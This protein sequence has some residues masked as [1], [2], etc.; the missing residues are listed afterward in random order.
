MLY[1]DLR[2]EF[3]LI[4]NSG[5]MFLTQSLLS[6]YLSLTEAFTQFLSKLDHL[7]SGLFCFDIESCDFLFLPPTLITK[8]RH[9]NHRFLQIFLL[10]PTHTIDGGIDTVANAH[11][12]LPTSGCRCWTI[13]RSRSLCISSCCCRTFSNYRILSKSS[14]RRRTISR[15]KILWKSSCHC[16]MTSGSRVLWRRNGINGC[17]FRVCCF[18]RWNRFV[19]TEDFSIYQL[20]CYIFVV[21]SIGVG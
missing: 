6:V 5:K 15:S 8:F 2:L 12:L 13:S 17:F 16:R 3:N 14:S 20:T 10:R 7:P 4:L 1:V 9:R 11:I 21:A 18:C 19:K